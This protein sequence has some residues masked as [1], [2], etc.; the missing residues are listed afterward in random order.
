MG[1]HS[2]GVGVIAESYIE[3]DKTLFEAFFS[4]FDKML[5]LLENEKISIAEERKQLLAL[6]DKLA[7]KL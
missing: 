1:E 6:F 5:Q 2:Q 4:R 3:N 7:A